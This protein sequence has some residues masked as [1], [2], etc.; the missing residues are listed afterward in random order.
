MCICFLIDFF[1]KRMGELEVEG[2]ITLLLVAC[3]DVGTIYRWIA[4]YW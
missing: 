2:G 4:W 1:L 3:F